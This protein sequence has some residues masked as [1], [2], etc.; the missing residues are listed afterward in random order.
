[1]QLSMSQASTV[2][3][4]QLAPH[5]SLEGVTAAASV[6]SARRRLFS[7]SVTDLQTS[8]AGD[9]MHWL[10][11]GSMEGSLS[12]GSLV[13]T[14]NLET[15]VEVPQEGLDACSSEGFPL[16]C[17]QQVEAVLAHPTSVNPTLPLTLTLP[18]PPQPLSSP[19]PSPPSP[20][21]IAMTEP[22]PPRA[23]SEPR[24]LQASA[25]V[26]ATSPRRCGSAR[27][28]AVKESPP[29]G[30]VAEKVSIFE[31]RCQSPVNSSV[32]AVLRR[33]PRAAPVPTPLG[34][35]RA[36]RRTEQRRL[37]GQPPTRPGATGLHG[38]AGGPTSVH[39]R[40][41]NK[42][43]MPQNRSGNKTALSSSNRAWWEEDTAVADVESELSTDDGAAATA[44]VLLRAVPS[45][46]DLEECLRRMSESEALEPPR[47]TSF[48]MS[49]FTSLN[50]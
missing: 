9:M 34:R 44:S 49:P 19:A 6:D 8:A 26:A 10:F 3:S 37:C 14:S 5:L 35:G 42:E 50:K 45:A 47:D 4:G 32:P 36:G 21:P 25:R 24:H 31:Q 17:R 29:R 38:R 2:P 13:A 11:D 39:A 1:L 12:T 23:L 46:S 33:G 20:S 22:V 28:N 7:P 41:V 15:L 48:G 16:E 43:G 18:S 27:R 40:P 30:C